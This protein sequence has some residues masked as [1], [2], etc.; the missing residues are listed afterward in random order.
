M[1]IDTIP[2]KPILNLP[3]DG[4]LK[5]DAGRTA[6]CMVLLRDYILELREE[7]RNAVNALITATGNE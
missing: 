1:S 5:H 4:V 6:D 2:D 7:T 3:I